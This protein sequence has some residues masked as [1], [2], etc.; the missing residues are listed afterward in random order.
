MDTFEGE[1][2]FLA[3]VKSLN[4]YKNLKNGDL[5]KLEIYKNWESSIIFPIFLEILQFFE[6]FCNICLVYIFKPRYIFLL[7]NGMVHDTL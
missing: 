7:H 6:D 5:Q 2:D 4:F 1:A 3:N